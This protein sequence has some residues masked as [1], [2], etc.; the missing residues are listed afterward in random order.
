MV[1]TRVSLLLLRRLKLEHSERAR[2]KAH[3]LLILG[4]SETSPPARVCRIRIE[5]RLEWDST[6]LFSTTVTCILFAE[7]SLLGKSVPLPRF[8]LGVAVHW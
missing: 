4:G 1:G 7:V 6:R 2:V 5:G 8:G 3:M